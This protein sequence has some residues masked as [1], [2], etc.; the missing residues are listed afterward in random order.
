MLNLFED[1]AENLIKEVG[2]KE[3]FYL[4]LLSFD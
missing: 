4:V 2:A 1:E 3:V